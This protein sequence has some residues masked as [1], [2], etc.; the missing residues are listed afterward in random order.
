MYLSA[1]MD[2]GW[3]AVKHSRNTASLRVILV[4]VVPTKARHVARGCLLCDLRVSLARSECDGTT[5][6]VFQ[7][8]SLVWR[9]LNLLV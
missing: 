9:T 7:S 4:I 8:R 3:E 5:V 6:W 2:Y 1:S